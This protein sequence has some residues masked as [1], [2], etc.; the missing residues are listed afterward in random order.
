MWLKVYT[1]LLI[2]HTKLDKTNTR[3]S[4][5]FKIRI[6]IHLVSIFAREVNENGLS[7]QNIAFVSPLLKL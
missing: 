3:L 4:S 1:F 5:G 6:Q 7:F 2:I